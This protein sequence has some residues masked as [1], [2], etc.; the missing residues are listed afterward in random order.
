MPTIVESVGRV[1][2]RVR[3]E[4]QSES[5]QVKQ[6]VGQD[7]RLLLW[8]ER[9]V[10][11]LNGFAVR[12]NDRFDTHDIESDE[13]GASAGSSPDIVVT[14][15]DG[16]PVRGTIVIDVDGKGF[17]FMQVSNT[18]PPGA[19]QITLRSGVDGFHSF[20][21]N[22]DGDR[23][24]RPGG[25]YKQ[26]FEI[27]KKN[28]AQAPAPT[29]AKVAQATADEGQALPLYLTSRGGVSALSFAIKADARLDIMQARLVEGLPHGA[30]IS[31]RETDDGLLM[32]NI[33]SPEPLPEGRI[34]MGHLFANGSLDFADGFRPVADSDTLAGVGTDTPD[35]GQTDSPRVDTP[36]VAQA[37][38]DQPNIDFSRAFDGFALAGALAYAD[39]ALNNRPPKP[40]RPWQ[41]ELIGKASDKTSATNQSLR[42]RLDQ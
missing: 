37:G 19:Y 14:G 31:L 5:V 24:G 17:S 26:H 39:S 10:P 28:G 23:D 27:G 32:V 3:L 2:N 8:V 34:L 29:V 38:A 25:D 7:A 20:F 42:I 41:S 1:V 22:L 11:L 15:P 21:G 18:L 36:A 13:P 4:G 16:K 9:F 33:T 6:P 12:F 35:F 30:S 40:A